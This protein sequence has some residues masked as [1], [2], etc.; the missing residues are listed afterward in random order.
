MNTTQNTTNLIVRLSGVE[1]SIKNTFKSNTL[2]ASLTSMGRRFSPLT[3]GAMGVYHFKFLFVFISLLANPLINTSAFAQNSMDALQYNYGTTNNQLQYVSDA[4]NAA[5]STV[6]VDNQTRTNYAYNA[7]G[8]LTKDEAENITSISWCINGKVKEVIKSTAAGNESIK[9]YY[10]AMGNKVKKVKTNVDG[11]QLTTYY[12]YQVTGDLLA[13]YE[14][15]GITTKKV[16]AK[17]DNGSDEA[18]IDL[19]TLVSATKFTRSITTKNYELKDHLGNVRATVSDVKEPNHGLTTYSSK[20][21]TANDYYAYGMQMPGRDY[22]SSNYRYGYQGKEKENDL[23]GTANAY[24]FGARILDPRLGRWLSTDPLADNQP[25][26]SPYKAFLDNP[27]Y[28]TDPDGKKEVSEVPSENNPMG[29]GQGGHA[30]TNRLTGTGD[31]G[32]RCYSD[33]T[34]VHPGVDLNW[35]T[36]ATS[37]RGLPII[38]TLTGTVIVADNDTKGDE[39]RSITIENASKNIRTRYLHLSEMSVQQG[40]QVNTED[41]IGRVGGSAKG[42]ENGRAVHLHYEVMISGDLATVL[43][44]RYNMQLQSATCNGKTEQYLTGAGSDSPILRPSKSGWFYIDPQAF[45]R[46]GELV[47]PNLLEYYI[48]GI[49][50]SIAGAEEELKLRRDIYRSKPAQDNIA[51]RMRTETAPMNKKK[52]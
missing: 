43:V 50:P 49:D 39:G 47:D 41:A 25:G 46:N 13:I 8:Q 11:T 5:N 27:I 1:A 52:K 42:S 16:E 7:N 32:P 20:L 37:D 23:K 10:D 21:T 34:V 24:D 30:V 38:S 35:G 4:V 45:S 48:Y 22:Q 19:T 28:W 6:D 33:A 31:M 29:D 2:N 36:S 9:F 18:S 51:A 14:Y 26:W 17:L 40:Q 12:T 3:R 15:D 44:E